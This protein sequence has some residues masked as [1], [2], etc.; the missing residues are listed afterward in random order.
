MIVLRLFWLCFFLV[1]VL[2]VE[3]FLSEDLS[4]GISCLLPCFYFMLAPLLL[5]HAC[6]PLHDATLYVYSRHSFFNQLCWS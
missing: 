5:F 1:E 6:S 2:A 3:C 4:N